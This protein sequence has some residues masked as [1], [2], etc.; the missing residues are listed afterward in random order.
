MPSQPKLVN[1][2]PSMATTTSSTRERSDFSTDASLS[3]QVPPTTAPVASRSSTAIASRFSTEYA[4]CSMA[5]S[6]SSTASGSVSARKPTRPRLTPMSAAALYR[7]SS[8]ARRKVPSPPKTMTISAPRAASASAGTTWATSMPSASASSSSNRTVMP[9]LASRAAEL[10]ASW[11]MS[12]RP[13]CTAS[14]TCRLP[15][16]AQTVGLTSVTLPP[17]WRPFV[18]CQAVRC[19]WVTSGARPLVLLGG[20][21]PAGCRRGRGARR[22][23][24]GGYPSRR[25]LLHGAAHVVLLRRAG[26]PA[27]PEEELDVAGRPGQRAGDDAGRPPTQVGGRPCH[28]QDG[29]LPVRRVAHHA[30]GAEALAADLELWLDHGQ[31][32]GLGGGAGGEGG[33]HQAQRDERQVGGD[34]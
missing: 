26:V 5:V 9:P 15:L 25:A 16:G 27:Q 6:V 29:V 11:T 34:P 28:R 1:G 19:P 30:A 14:S 24:G 17:R 13:V 23:V 8:A 22:P 20:W 21:S 18:A 32:V 10:R 33:E 4:H 7:A 12:W 3:A 31:Q 2:R